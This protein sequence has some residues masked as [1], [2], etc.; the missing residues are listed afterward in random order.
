MATIKSF[1]SVEQSKKLAAILPL[2]S[3]DMFYNGVQDL[4]KEKIYNIPIDG[5]SITVRTGHTITE[6]GIKANLLLPCW[7]LAALLKLMPNS[8]NI[9]IDNVYYSIVSFKDE[10]GTT[11]FRTSQYDNPIDAAFEMIVWLKKNEKL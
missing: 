1:T 10:Y 7:S 8:Q 5:S 2:E 9:K 11:S 3:A 6:E 4:Y